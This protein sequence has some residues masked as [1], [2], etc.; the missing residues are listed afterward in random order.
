MI[1]KAQLDQIRNAIQSCNL[2]FLIGSGASSPF[3]STLGNIE[4][5]LTKVEQSDV[6]EAERKILKCS[7][8]KRYFDEVMAKNLQVLAGGAAAAPVLAHYKSFLKAINNILLR[9][10][11]SI[12]GK[13]VNLFTTNIDIF[14]EKG[15]E[16][17]GVE[18]NDGFNGRFAPFFS[19]SNFHKTRFKRSLHFDNVSEL[20]VFNL[21]K[22]HGSLT[23]RLRDE[24]GIEFS[25]DLGRLVSL[26]DIAF[27]DGTLVDISRDG[28]NCGFDDA[29]AHLARYP[30]IDFF[31][32]GYEELLVINPTL[33]K[34]KHTILNYTYYELLRIFSNELEKDNTVL[35]VFGFSFADAHI[36]EIV[37]R[38]A[39]SNP[40][41]MVYIAAHTLGS[42]ASIRD[43]FGDTNVK[44]ANIVLLEPPAAVNGDGS[45]FNLETLNR[46]LFGRLFGAESRPQTSDGGAM[47][48]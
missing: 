7:I 13:E 20:P 26:R 17:L 30:S 25:S 29:V 18:F 8:Y 40:T 34:F 48:Q 24:N 27:E 35:F 42:A 11:S 31:I 22:L 28:L 46:E 44:N 38:S 6:A 43:R 47:E 16:D 1:P 14:I 10:R 21:L 41:L 5:L 2:N 4:T 3:L 33:E 23:W 12:L 32:S 19:L 15:I 9:R 37:L 39:N 45:V 36:R